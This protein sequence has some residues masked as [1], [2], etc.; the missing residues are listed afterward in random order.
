MSQG[1]LQDLSHLFN[2]EQLSVHKFGGTSMATIEAMRHSAKVVL[3]VKGPVIVVVSAAAGITRALMHLSHPNTQLIEQQK[4]LAEITER[5][6]EFLTYLKHPDSIRQEL[7]H[8]L[9][10][11]V[12]LN[13]ELQKERTLW[14]VDALLSIGECLSSLVFSQVLADEGLNTVWFDVRQVMKTSDH[15]GEAEPLLHEIK[16][17]AAALLIPLCRE[18]VL[19][20]QGYIGMTKEGKTTTLGKESSDYSAALLAEATGAAHFAIWSDMPGVFTADPKLTHAARPIS[21][22]KMQNALALTEAGA[23]VLH[24]RTM[25]PALRANMA[26][27]VGSS[28][29]LAGGTWVL[30]DNSLQEQPHICAINLRQEQILLTFHHRIAEQAPL[31]EILTCLNTADVKPAYIYSDPLCTEIL[32]D[33]SLREF[34]CESLLSDKLM[35]DLQTISP[36]TD[37]RGLQLI[38]I[39]GDRLDANAHLREV[40]A[41]FMKTCTIRAFS[42]GMSAHSLYILVQETS[43]R[44]KALVKVLHQ[45]LFES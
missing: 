36:V 19:V 44:A 41:D 37:E 15:F 31:S 6:R 14:Q 8:L 29:G 25:L 12:R 4:L 20:T 39:I 21:T 38:A 32:I 34:R 24:P 18:K 26:F 28:Q 42:F 5:H 7:E 27:F 45:Q 10:E 13:A 9:A 2:Q 1:V 43:E 40:L 23:K 33:D 16:A 11:V 35:L 3:Q 17:C 30:Q 22:M